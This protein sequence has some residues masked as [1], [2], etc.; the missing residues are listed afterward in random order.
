MAAE[1]SYADHQPWQDLPTRPGMKGLVLP[2]KNNLD[3]ATIDQ[4]V[5]MR[6]LEQRYPGPLAVRKG[7]T[8]VAAIAANIH[9]G[10]RAYDPSSGV[11]ARVWGAGTSAYLQG[12]GAI[13]TGLSGRP[14][15]FVPF[16]TQIS[17]EPWLIVADGN[18]MFKVRVSD[19][20][21]LPLGL[22]A[23]GAPTAVLSDLLTTRFA[24]F[25]PTDNTEAANWTATAGI[26]TA[27]GSTTPGVPT[28][29]DVGGVSGNA[30]QI[31]T[32][33]GGIPVNEGYSSIGGVPIT[34]DASILQA[35]PL[36][37]ASDDD[38]VHIW[39]RVDRPEFVS[40]VRIYL[41]CAAGFDP[42]IVPGT[43]ETANQDAYIRAFRSNDWTPFLAQVE[44]AVIQ[45]QTIRD[46]TLTEDFQQ[47]QPDSGNQRVIEPGDT[48]A[49]R[50]ISRQTS[51]EVQGGRGVWSEAR[52]RR[53][54][55]APRRLG[56][57]RD[58]ERPRLVDAH[59]PG[60]RRHHHHQRGRAGL[61]RRLLPHRRVRP[62]H[63][64]PGGDGVHLLRDQLRSSNR[65]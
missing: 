64:R 41:V 39:L 30:I 31:E 24:A 61:P 53:D 9:S 25:D 51:T 49:S 44:A 56:E 16:Y 1:G 27:G 28:I 29:T 37:P 38:L 19:G 50:Q 7:Q 23:P 21:V 15:T 2:A 54:P 13:Q 3:A 17:D 57:N 5:K 12:T 14:L 59:R 6:N 22:P 33:P 11:I 42:T 47:D 60:R 46:N 26:N 52:D 8:Q 62:G 32:D 4:L 55:A 10:G 18:R 34:V 45:G 36:F 58:R 48:I 20:L 63:Q 35:N 40:E 43:S 65:C